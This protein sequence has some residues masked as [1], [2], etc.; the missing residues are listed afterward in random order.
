[1]V[2]LLAYLL[3]WG[4]FSLL[5]VALQYRF[6]RA[7]LLSPMMMNSTNALF[8][9]VLLLA[10]GIYQSLRSSRLACAIVAIPRAISHGIGA[11][12]PPGR[13]AWALIT[14]DTAFA[15]AGA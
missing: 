14:G 9:A 15:A 8:A 4:G 2:F 5:A 12:G 6:V 3:A 11:P 13:C 7:G 10:A 1:M